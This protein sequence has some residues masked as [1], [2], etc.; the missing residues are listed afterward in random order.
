[1]KVL[2]VGMGYVGSAL[3]VLLRAQGDEVWGVRRNPGSSD[4]QVVSADAASGEGLSALPKDFDQIA[5]CVSPDSRSD[6]HYREAYPRVARTIGATFPQARLLL[7]SSTSVYAQARGEE[8]TETSAAQ[9]E[10]LTAQS[11]IEAEN[12]ILASGSDPCVV[13]ASGIYGPG[14]TS[15]L[16]LL[17]RSALSEEDS[18]VWTNRIHR[19]DLARALGFLIEDRRLSGV[20]N[21]SDTKPATLG[22]IASWVRNHPLRSHLPEVSR[23]STRTRK[24][25][26]ILP[27]RLL[28]AGFSFL[29][30]TFRE[31]YESV[32]KQ[33]AQAS[34][35]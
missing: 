6:H 24:S 27:A 33:M 4:E 12:I 7:I 2:V 14:R 20:F 3:T 23:S 25:R 17:A 34:N 22:E 10:T 11:I 26:R 16:S 5:I 1:M 21:A 8:V 30:P 32:L 15:T 13:R 35:R 28:E 19:D 18:G 29:Y 31:G 9:N